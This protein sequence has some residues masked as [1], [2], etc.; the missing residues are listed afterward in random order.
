MRRLVLQA[1]ALA[2]FLALPAV[3]APALGE[4]APAD[5]HV[6]FVDLHDGDVVPQHLHVKFGASGIKVRKAGEDVAD[7]LSGH[8]HLLI[9]SAA[10]PQGQIIPKDEQHLHY[11]AGQTEADIVLTPGAHTLTL[12]FGDGAHGSYGPALSATL[13]VTA[14]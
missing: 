1:L 13:H 14:K 3:A 9:D 12:Q 11:G 10:V 6:Y 7:R 2:S 8:H 5:A 4:G